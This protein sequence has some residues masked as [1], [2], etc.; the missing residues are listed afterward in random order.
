M[1]YGHPSQ[2]AKQP[3]PPVAV[4]A[5]AKVT[6]RERERREST[7]WLWLL[8]VVLLCPFLFAKL[9][10]SLPPPL[11]PACVSQNRLLTTAVTS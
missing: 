8:P 9:H 1:P 7:P 2:P 5:N 3:Q 10:Y 6:S 11:P 4:A